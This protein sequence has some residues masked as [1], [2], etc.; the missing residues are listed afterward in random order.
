[1]DGIP[2]RGDKTQQ[3]KDGANE[4]YMRVSGKWLA[5]HEH[6]DS[7]IEQ[8][9]YT[10]KTADECRGNIKLFMERFKVFETITEGDIEQWVLDLL[11]DL[12]LRTVKKKIGFIRTYWKYC[13]KRGYTQSNPR[14]VLTGEIYRE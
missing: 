3:D 13:K 8:A 5:T 4:T 2:F 14:D 11:D 9:E 1:M 12:S 10:P 7:F 6:V